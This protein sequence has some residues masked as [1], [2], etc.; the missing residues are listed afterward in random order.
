MVRT[1]GEQIGGSPP[2]AQ[3]YNPQ[4][5]HPFGINPE[6]LSQNDKAFVRQRMAEM[7]AGLN[8]IRREEEQKK[9]QEKATQE[10]QKAVLLK[11]KKEAQGSGEVQGKKRKSM[12]QRVMGIMKR[13]KQGGTGEMAKKP[14]Q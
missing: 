9:K 12:M 6:E 3:E 14:S 10:Q 11:R 7:E 5:L 13:D 1:I 2:P 4:E 8:K